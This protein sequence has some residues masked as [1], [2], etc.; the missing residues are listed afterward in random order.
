MSLQYVISAVD[1]FSGTFD[2]LEKKA[3]GVGDKLTSVGKKL[4]VGVTT[5]IVGL[6]TAAVVTA[7]SFDTAM[8]KVQAISGATGD[9]FAAMRE[10][11]K[12]LGAT[13]VFS[14]SQAAD[15]MEFL[16]RAGFKT[17][18]IMSA[19]PGML[20]L[21]AASAIDL[22]VAADITSNIMSGFGI[23][24][25]KAGMVADVLAAATGRS[26]TSVESMGESMKMV[27][28]VSAGLGISLQETAAAIGLLGDAGIQGGMAGTTL[29]A[30]LLRLASPAASAEEAMAALGVEFFDSA[31]QMKS[32]TEIIRLLENAMSG[33]TDQ[34]KTQNLEMLFGKNAVS[35]W[36]AIIDAGADKLGQFTDEMFASE[37]AAANMAEVMLD[38]LGGSM[39]QLQSAIEGLMISFG[40]IM[41][42]TIQQVTEWLTTLV[43]WFNGLDESQ[44]ETIITVGLVVAAIGP[45]LWIIGALVPGIKA[46]GAALTF[47]AAN[48]VG[49]IITAIGALVA[50]LI[51]LFNTNETFREV[52]VA[53]WEWIKTAAMTIFGAIQAFWNEWGSSIL[54]FFRTVW[55]TVKTVFDAAFG[56]IQTAVTF[57]FNEIKAFWDKWG[58]TIV[59][60]FRN[61]FEIVKI[62][63]TTVFN[64][65][66]TVVETVFNWIKAFWDKWG[67]LIIS[68]FEVAFGVVKT[69]FENTWN[70]IKS[71]IETVIGVISG[72]IK[73][74]LSVLKGDWEGAW[75]A[76][77]GIVESIWDGIVGVIKGAA[78]IIIGIANGVIGAFENMLNFV[79]DAIN[80]IPEFTVPD[81][82][83]LIGGKTFS[84]PKVPTISLPKIPALDIG[85]DRVLSDGLAMLH[86]GEAV[87]PAAEVAGGGFS[88]GGT[89]S[90]IVIHVSAADFTDP[91][92]VR[93]MAR[94][95][96]AEIGRQVG[97]K[98]T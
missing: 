90:Q 7:S 2:A 80:K 81:W 94:I 69:I 75:D 8:S 93:K 98:R 1:N 91:D 51:Y 38:N 20:D 68:Q 76:I 39:V 34:Q 9:D 96:G 86:A 53:V 18:D 52:V 22:G 78:N 64:V 71:V 46:V 92:H 55:D 43:T 32:L 4:T 61:Y 36:M 65:I 35:G 21:A 70:V 30:G 82:V 56:A 88:G 15:G 67:S 16:A 89:G 13:T 28:P 42:P 12:E 60:A 5:P 29:R 73:L 17:N 49:L 44:K 87:V 54:S 45:L 27:A 48:P 24:A 79:G 59:E 19:M 10:Q 84:L 14:A 33:M 37:G 77:K 25:D 11:A 40:E 3:K 97:G 47:L 50:G 62:V 83:P 74:F 66:K 41:I 63:W 95:F 6:G 85:T 26:N 31:G 23:A 72:I 57:I 58:D